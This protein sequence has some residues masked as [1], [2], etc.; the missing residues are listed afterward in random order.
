MLLGSAPAA[1]SGRE[2]A[3]KK[4]QLSWSQEVSVLGRKVRDRC[5]GQQGDQHTGG[6]C[7]RAQGLLDSGDTGQPPGRWGTD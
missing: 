2:D 6:E 4:A 7:V 3:P 5:A 1:G